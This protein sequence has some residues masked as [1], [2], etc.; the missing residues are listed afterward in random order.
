MKRKWRQLEPGFY[1][2][3]L[4]RG[5]VRIRIHLARY[6]AGHGLPASKGHQLA[7][8]QLMLRAAR[9]AGIKLKRDVP[10]AESN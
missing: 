5:R 9:K 1:Q 10:E 8:A 7:A 3:P 4:D 6:L 2:R